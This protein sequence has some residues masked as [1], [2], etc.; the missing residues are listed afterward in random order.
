LGALCIAATIG[1]RPT[2]A[3]TALLAIAL[4]FPQVRA[5]FSASTWRERA[6]RIQALRF[7]CALIIPAMLIVVPVIAYNAMRFGSFT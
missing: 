6:T 1:C 5:V 4:F 3:L 2:F 7:L